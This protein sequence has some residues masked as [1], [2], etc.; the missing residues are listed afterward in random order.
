MAIAIIGYFI[1]MKFHVLGDAEAWKEFATYLGGI[2]A[3]LTAIGTIWITYLVYKLNDDGHRSERYF[4]KI[5]DLYWEIQKTHNIIQKEGNADSNTMTNLENGI[6][7]QVQLMRYYLNRF[8]N[9]S[10]SIKSF[11][12][13]LNNLWFEPIN[14]EYHKSLAWEF[15]NFCFYANHS[16]KRPIKPLKGENGKLIDIDY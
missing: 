14:N 12:L 16:L 7:I 6:R 4:E 8:P 2:V 11:D 3:P 10:H 15:E 1:S 5:A 13:A 9:L